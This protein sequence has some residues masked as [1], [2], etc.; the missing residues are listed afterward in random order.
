MAHVVILGL[1]GA[2]KTSIG[3]IVAE[4]LGLPLIDGDERLA[5]QTGGRTAAEIADEQGI[6][7]LHDMEAE[8]ALAALD[9]ADPAVIGPASSVCESAV[10][11]DAL[12]GH[13]VVWLTAPAEH[14]A[15]KAVRKSHR[16]LVHDG[17]PVELFRQQIATREPLIMA[18][19]PLVIDVA[20]TDD[21]AAADAIVSYVD[22]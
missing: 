7:A 21:E 17:D 18:L 6:D 9:L 11:R 20:S 10:V 22:R 15:D 5:E 3:R 19:D 12:V 1:M 13:H 2:G 4:R 8:I 14:L 16:P